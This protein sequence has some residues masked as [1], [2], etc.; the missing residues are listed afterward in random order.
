MSDFA[1]PWDGYEPVTD[2]LERRQFREAFD[3]AVESRR[4]DEAVALLCLIG[5]DQETAERIVDLTIRTA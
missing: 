5:V 4:R 3:D 2:A 1:A